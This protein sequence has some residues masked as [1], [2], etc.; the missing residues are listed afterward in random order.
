MTRRGS[1]SVQRGAF[2]PLQPQEDEG[3]VDFPVQKKGL[4]GPSIFVFVTEAGTIEGWNPNV[5]PDHAIVA[6]DHSAQD[7]VYK[8]VALA[9]EKLFA[10]DFHNNEVEVF[11]DQ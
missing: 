11:D 5:D 6:V 2:T 7:A 4:S 10:A 9:H 8:G 3:D 1:A